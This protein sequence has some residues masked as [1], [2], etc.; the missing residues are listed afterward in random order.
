MDFCFMETV[1]SNQTDYQVFTKDALDIHKTENVFNQYSNMSNII[2]P[3]VSSFSWAAWGNYSSNNIEYTKHIESVEHELVSIGVVM[4]EQNQL[5]G[6]TIEKLIKAFNPYRK[7]VMKRREFYKLMNLLD[8]SLKRQHLDIRLPG[9]WYKFGFL[10][11]DR[12]LDVI[13]PYQFSGNCVI[14]DYIY[15]STTKVDYSGEFSTNEE[16]IISRTIDLLHAKY[17][18]KEGYGDLAKKDSYEINSPYK[19]NT[20]FQDY[21]HITNTNKNLISANLKSDM[22]KKLDE[23][24]PEFPI[25]QFPELSSLHFEWDDTTRL[26]LDYAPERIKMEVIRK[27][28]DAF[29]DIYSKQVRIID[30]QN[31]P[32]EIVEKWKSDYAYELAIAGKIVEDI[33]DE[34]ISNYYTPSEKSKKLAEIF[35]QDTYYM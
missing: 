5:L 25:E 10:I 34:V 30:N 9:Y 8:H 3:V 13:L 24:L 12:F 1:T 6:Y 11:E 18:N 22:I 33:R 14:N 23:L 4:G 28:R 27:L 15:P 21:L 17:G 19:F 31:L 7:E 20:I 32:E 2:K 35:M 16:K 29:W 26:I